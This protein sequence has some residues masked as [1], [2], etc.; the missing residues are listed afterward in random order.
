MNTSAIKELAIYKFK[1]TSVGKLWYLQMSLALWT[2]LSSKA[3]PKDVAFRE[4][5]GKEPL[6]C[7]YLCEH[8][9][10]DKYG[11]SIDCCS[12]CLVDWGSPDDTEHPCL[13]VYSPY[14]RWFDAK[15]SPSE[16]RGQWM[17]NR[18]K[19]VC[20]LHT[21]AILGIVGDSKV[22]AKVNR[23]IEGFINRFMVKHV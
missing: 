14:D 5:R 9:R 17:I 4:L 23:M 20:N 19:D 10:V 2:I 12:N 21:K 7:C 15:T 13:S 18:A 6:F 1:H 8:A 3:V 16:H 22:L 11:S